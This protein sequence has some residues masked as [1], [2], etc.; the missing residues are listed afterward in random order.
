MSS[1][2]KVRL[3]DCFPYIKNGRNIKQSREKGGIPIT[4]IETLSNE[5]FNRDKVGYA[6]IFSTAGLDNYILTDGDILMSHI[7]SIPYLGR[8]VMYRALPDETII[9]GMNLLRLKAD[10]SVVN[11][12]YAEAYFKSSFF[13]HQILKI[14][15]KA[16]N[17]ASFSTSSLKELEFPLVSLE[18]QKSVAANLHFINSQIDQVEQ[19]IAQLD[20]L[21]KSRFVEMFGDPSS[22]EKR[23]PV[24][25]GSSLFKIGNGKTK[26][27][28]ERYEDGIPAYGGNGISWYAKESLVNSPT[29]V[30][31]RVGRHCGNTRLVDEPCWV[32]DNAMYIKK[33]LGD[34]FDLVYLDTLMRLVGFNKYADK[35]D[36]WKITQ[37]PFMDFEFPLP[38]LALQ[39]DFAAFAA[40]VDKTRAIAQQQIDKLQT[41]Y[42][43]LAQEYFA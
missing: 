15:K 37:Q 30:I 21:V 18:E 43:S 33:F 31:G 29:I 14:A 8:A 24:K 23:F 7:N 39:Q 11:P 27:A 2:E 22:N 26:P 36:L 20:Q 41:L 9:H 38:P 17:Q 28:A 3:G 5:R 40:Q 42:D 4:R 10:R 12:E 16:V 6:D 32:T 19:Q 13:K 35:G 1:G 25:L 34:D